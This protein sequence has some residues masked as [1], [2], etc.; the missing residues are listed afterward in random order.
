[1]S[2][3]A[4]S[5]DKDVLNVFVK[6]RDE[7]LDQARQVTND[8][9]RGIRSAFWAQDSETI[10]YL[11]DFEGDENFHLYSLS[12]VDPSAEAL[13]LT[14]GKNVKASN[15]MTNKR[16]PN[17]ILVGTNQRD[18]KCFDIYRCN[19][20]TGEL[21]LDTENPGDVVGFGS[22]DESFEVREAVVRN[23]A[24]SSTTIRIRDNATSPWRDLITFP[25]GEEGNLVE[26]CPD[27]QTAWLKS[28]LG[29]ETTALLKI[30]LQTGET[31][32]EVFCNDKCNCGAV[33][34]DPDTKELRAV[35]YNYARLER[36]FFDDEL[37]KDYEFLASV[38]PE[39]AE[40]LPSSKTRDEKTW[41]VGFRR[42]DGPIEYVVYDQENKTTEPLFVSK[43][44]LLQ[45]KFAPME[46]VRIPARDGLE[47]VAYLTRARTDRPTP[48]I[49]LVHGGPWARDS[50]GFNPQAQWFANRGYATLQVN[51]RGSTGYGKTFLHR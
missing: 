36:Q 35:S 46:D 12:I 49:L 42:S 43:P 21:T 20:K 24:D 45:Y 11:Q 7:P 10:L 3:L 38:A 37:K 13:D 26:F 2:F 33:S 40:V 30:D 44:D 29:R 15:V 25:Y 27:G 31:L 17:E 16:Y 41:I 34:L 22:E 4:P 48:L 19:Y 51:Y 1:M 8:T 14:P 18:E 5:V 50:W 28:S 39:G 32:E 23:Q 47:L 9:S 6:R